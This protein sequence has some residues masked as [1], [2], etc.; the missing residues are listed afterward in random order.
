MKILKWALKWTYLLFLSLKGCLYRNRRIFYSKKLDLRFLL[1]LDDLVDFL[2]FH[3]GVFQPEII[4]SIALI[5]TSIKCTHF[6]DVG[7]HIGQMSLY[8]AKHFT[9]VKI[10]SFEPNLHLVERQKEN[11]QQ[12]KL[13][14]Q[15]EN[16]ALYSKSGFEQLVGDSKR[17]KGEYFKRN[18]GKYT[19][20][21]TPKNDKQT[22]FRVSTTSLDSYL[23]G[24][25]KQ[26]ILVKLDTEGSELEILKGANNLFNQ[27]NIIVIIELL[28]SEYSE[29]CSQI[30]NFFT[31][32]SYSIFDLQLKPLSI[33]DLKDGDYIFM[34]RTQ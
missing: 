6:I 25:K 30:C 28:F 10:I 11:M 27:N 31:E 4:H 21:S 1:D 14:Y 29:K 17:Y 8:V 13:S 12:N 3:K 7:S 18:T 2:I 26:T 15:I 5:L 33:N 16:V 23:L 24:T 19:I 20:V 34:Y 22:I 32:R 9:S